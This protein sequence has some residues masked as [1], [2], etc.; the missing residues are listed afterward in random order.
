[1]RIERLTSWP[2]TL[3]KFSCDDN[4]LP[5]SCMQHEAV[6]S[7]F[8]TIWP[9]ILVCGA[10]ASGKTSAAVGWITKRG[11]GRIFRNNIDRMIVFMPEA[12]RRS[13]KDDPFSAKDG[14]AQVSHLYNE[15]NLAN[16]TE[17]WT[18]IE[19]Y[20]ANGETS[21]IFLD[22]CLAELK[23]KDIQQLFIKI[24]ANRRHQQCAVILCVQSYLRVP[25]TIRRCA[26]TIA[27]VGRVKNRTEAMK[28]HEELLSP[29]MTANEFGI[30]SNHIYA[31]D[32][33]GILLIDIH[34]GKVYN[35]FKERI[36]LDHDDPLEARAS[37]ASRAVEDSEEESTK[38]PA[39][40]VPESK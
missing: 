26:S 24:A 19:G 31:S 29:L 39:K 17:A 9:L 40:S 15:L 8:G 35:A 3:P 10:P 20:A 34:H 16:L 2:V 37:R 5:P 4:I 25:T 18:C 1:M 13:L 12:S 30:I 14:V 27:L 21:L 38:I 32:P 33:H 36:H 23:N 11:K 28:I 7:C 22:D 6:S